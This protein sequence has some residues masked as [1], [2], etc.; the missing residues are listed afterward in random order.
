LPW[1]TIHSPLAVAFA[2][3]RAPDFVVARHRLI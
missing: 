1:W 2:L 3:Q